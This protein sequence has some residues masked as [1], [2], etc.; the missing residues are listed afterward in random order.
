MYKNYNEYTVTTTGINELKIK[1]ISNSGNYKLGLILS[2]AS[3]KIV[4]ITKITEYYDDINS[5]SGKIAFIKN[6][7]FLTP[8]FWQHNRERF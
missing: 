5:S 8:I 6:I 1:D 3:R 2:N 7:E 4:S